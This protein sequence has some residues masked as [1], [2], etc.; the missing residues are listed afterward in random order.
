MTA[1]AL[2]NFE[3]YQLQAILCRCTSGLVKAGCTPREQHA[4]RC[5]CVCDE[6]TSAV[7]VLLCVAV[8]FMQVHQEL[9]GQYYADR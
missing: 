2:C 3:L 4:R 9:L 6:A 1:N 8:L 5:C 7:F